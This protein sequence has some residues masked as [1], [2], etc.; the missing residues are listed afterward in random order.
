[1]VLILFDIPGEGFYSLPEWVLE[2]HGAHRRHRENSNSLH[3]PR[4]VVNLLCHTPPT[5]NKL[6][7]HLM[8]AMAFKPSRLYTLAM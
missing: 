2:N 6:K 1:M 4:P 5:Q 8:A 7:S 3:P